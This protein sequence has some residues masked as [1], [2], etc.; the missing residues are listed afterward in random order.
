VAERR[1][2]R[3]SCWTAERLIRQIVDGLI[4]GVRHAATIFVAK[5]TPRSTSLVKTAL[6][7]P[8]LDEP[9]AVSFASRTALSSATSLTTEAD[10]PASGRSHR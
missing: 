1:Y 10:V 2:R 4:V 6:E 3:G 8:N 9:N 7:R 5:C